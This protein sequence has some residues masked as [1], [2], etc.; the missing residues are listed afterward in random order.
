MSRANISP[1]VPDV[2]TVSIAG[3]YRNSRRTVSHVVIISI[4]VWT[5][6][7]R[8]AG[9]AS[10]K[11]FISD[12]GKRKSLDPGV[13]QFRAIAVLDCYH[14]SMSEID[15]LTT[16]RQIETVRDQFMIESDL[17]LMST[18]D[19]AEQEYRLAR[20][21]KLL[22]AYNEIKILGSFAIRAVEYL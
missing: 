20:I 15:S 19:R 1:Y 7:S 12:Q 10:P 2:G 8:R 18:G 5:L 21:D 16:E 22:D 17:Y 4:V 9:Y 13:G 3:S 11:S 6:Q 14:K